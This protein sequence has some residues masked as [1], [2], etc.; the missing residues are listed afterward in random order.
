M[1]STGRFFALCL[2]AISTM[3]VGSA[4]PAAAAV[5][6][7]FVVPSQTSAGVLLNSLAVADFNG[8][9]RPDVVVGDSASPGLTVVLGLGQGKLGPPI[10]S[11]LP[12]NATAI[13]VAVADFNGDGRA[14]VAVA[15]ST[16][17]GT[18]LAVMRGRG[19]GTFVLFT[20]IPGIKAVGVIAADLDGDGDADV[21]ALTDQPTGDALSV[22]LGNGSGGFAA[23]VTYTPPFSIT[24]NDL[25]SADVD[26]DGDLDLVYGAGCPVVRLNTGNGTFGPEICNGDPQAR[27]GYYLAV[28][29]L[30]QDGIVDLATA[31]DGHITV[32]IGNGTGRFTITQRYDGLAA[33][34]RGL[35]VA[36]VTGD[37]K[38]DIVAASD[39][40]TVVLKGAGNATYSGFERWV[41]GGADNT[42]VDLN[43][44][45]RRDLVSAGGLRSGE[46]SVAFGGVAAGSFRAPRNFV[47]LGE[48]AVGSIVK[49]GDLNA[50]GRQDVVIAV[51]GSPVAHLNKG[52]GRLGPPLLGSGFSEIQ[53]M[54]LADVNNDDRL[55]VV[56]GAYQPGDTDN[57][58][59]ML[60]R[61]NG[62][63]DPPST[64]NNGSGAAVLG[65]T[66][67]TSTPTAIQTSSATPSRRCPCCEATATAPSALP[68]C[69]ARAPA[70]SVRH[71]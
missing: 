6:P 34:F 37:G 59:V 25:T 48:F 40:I 55:D 5:A 69:Q 58:F 29:D 2:A 45:G 31:G 11:A 39:D 18:G 36:D 12:A 50:D 67:G 51:A 68:S 35:D 57:L 1:H 53:S 54:T 49:S 3:F 42:A 44:D 64:L 9:G 62:R 24:Y 26:G 19:D 17:G 63:F 46:I 32:G 61:G 4:A 21:A 10:K 47:S 27:W 33:D 13:D 43:A 20:T 30:N 60:G 16:T 28:G 71:C 23:P 56:A 70:I 14:D 8:D 65:V 7:S 22:A 15:T 41:T 52:G 66:V 38:A